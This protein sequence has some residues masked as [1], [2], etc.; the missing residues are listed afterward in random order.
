MRTNGLIRDFHFDFIT[1][2]VLAGWPLQ[3]QLGVRRRLWPLAMVAVAHCKPS[4]TRSKTVRRLLQ[5]ILD[6]P[7]PA[8]VPPTKLSAID[9]P[10]IPPLP[11]TPR[12]YAPGCRWQ[13]GGSRT[14]PPALPAPRKVPAWQR[15]RR[16]GGTFFS[17]RLLSVNVLQLLWTV[18]ISEGFWRRSEV[19]SLLGSE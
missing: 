16:R 4:G 17:S 6:A 19:E 9:V 10:P 8:C 3:G 12:S 2:R 1:T 13:E 7:F 15:P 5:E 11:A 18:D 14:T